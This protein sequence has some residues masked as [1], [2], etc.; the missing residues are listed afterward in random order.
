MKKGQKA[1]ARVNKAYSNH[2]SCNECKV[3]KPINKVTK[4]SFGDWVC[5]V[6]WPLFEMEQSFTNLLRGGK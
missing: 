1:R 3:S 4:S 5:D 6:C 2:Q